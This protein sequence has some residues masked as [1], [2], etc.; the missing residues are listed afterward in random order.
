[1]RIYRINRNK[2]IIKKLSPC[3]LKVEY[4]Q[5][6]YDGVLTPAHENVILCGNRVIATA[7]S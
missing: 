6:R 2:E 1:M 3:S 4:P 7:I 5:K